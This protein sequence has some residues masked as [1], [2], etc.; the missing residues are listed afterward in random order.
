M[1]TTKSSP[2]LLKALRARLD[3][4]RSR[5]GVTERYY[6][7]WVREDLRP[8]IGLS[9]STVEQALGLPQACLMPGSRQD[10]RDDE[11]QY[12]F[13]TLPE[14]S[15]GGGPQLMIGFDFR[16]LATVAYWIFSK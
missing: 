12:S 1:P 14:G 16:G 3:A 5:H 2:E 7:N 9:S 13:Y 8:L 4:V 15:L 11:W 6:E 10:C